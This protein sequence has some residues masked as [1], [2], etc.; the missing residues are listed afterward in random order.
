MAHSSDAKADTVHNRTNR[1][2]PNCKR[3]FVPKNGLPKY[4]EG[5]T[6]QTWC[7]KACYVIL[8]PQVVEEIQCL[9][10]PTVFISKT[11]RSVTCGSEECQKKRI[12]ENQ[13]KWLEDPKNR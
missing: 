5:Q 9:Y 6:N 7:S 11:K 8:Y 12:K 13:R 10:C 1:L 2:C 3:Y 4:V